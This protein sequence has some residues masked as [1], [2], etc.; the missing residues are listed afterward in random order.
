MYARPTTTVSIL[1]GSSTDDLGD[2]LEGTTVSASGVPASILERTKRVFTPTDQR[3]QTITYYTGRLP[4]G[5]AVTVANRVRDD[6]SGAVYAIDN[7]SALVSP[8]MTPD[9]RLDLRRVSS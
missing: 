7:V 2:V 5:T 6:V 1:S 3:V 4:A 8:V 9:L